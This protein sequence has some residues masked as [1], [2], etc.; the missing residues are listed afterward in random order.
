MF[1]RY[2]QMSRGRPALRASQQRKSCEAIEVS[3]E[4]EVHYTAK[5]DS[6]C[7]GPKQLDPTQETILIC[8]HFP[9]AVA[10][11]TC[12]YSSPRRSCLSSRRGPSAGFGTSASAI[13]YMQQRPMQRVSGSSGTLY[14]GSKPVRGR[15]SYTT[16]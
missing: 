3:R 10:V 16:T 2:P 13:P 4:L 11:L 7:T 8:D 12:T 14:A 1:A 15:E 9:G 6:G 5:R